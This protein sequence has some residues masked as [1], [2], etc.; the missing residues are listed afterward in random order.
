MAPFKSK[1]FSDVLIAIL[2]FVLTGNLTAQNLKQ[3]LASL[4]GVNKAG[5]I[6]EKVNQ[7]LY[8]NGMREDDLRNVAIGE[9][10]SSGITVVQNSVMQKLPGSPYL[11]I[12]AGAVKAKLGDLYAVKLTVEFRQDVILSRNP[13]QIYYGAATWSAS[14]VGIFT[15]D[16]LKEIKEYTKEMV[17]NFITD[18]IKANKMSNTH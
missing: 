4:R 9:L 15:A 6:V 16:K 2:L 14:D 5:V 10:D 11:Y 18:Y 13:K 12:N 17:K 1:Y 7:V 8:N 3:S